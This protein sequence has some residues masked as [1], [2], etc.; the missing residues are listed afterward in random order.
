MPAIDFVALTVA[1]TGTGI[2]PEIVGK[3]FEP[4]FTTKPLG[5]GTGLGLSTV[6]GIVKQTGGFIFASPGDGGGTCFA[7]YLPATD[8]RRDAGCRGCR[9]PPAA[10]RAPFSSSRTTARSASSSSGR[11]SAH[12]LT[13][14]PPSDGGVALDMLDTATVD[15]LVSD[16]VMPGIDGVE[17]L[18]TIRARRPCAAGRADVGLCRAAAAPRARP[19]G[20]RSSSPSRSPPTIWSTPCKPRSPHVRLTRR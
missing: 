10:A 6:Y 12:G 4:F 9:R 18:E 20:V 14:S 11:C 1:D 19:R 17:L 16:V 8:P 7:I 13:S 5:Q 3:I 2:A 15:V